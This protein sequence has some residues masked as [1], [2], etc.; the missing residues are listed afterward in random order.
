M[1][2]KKFAT[3]SNKRKHYKVCKRELKALS[4]NIYMPAC[5]E[6]LGQDL[7]REGGSVINPVVLYSSAVLWRQGPQV[8]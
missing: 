1:F 7:K 3:N 2:K 6:V 8:I 5:Q 4:T